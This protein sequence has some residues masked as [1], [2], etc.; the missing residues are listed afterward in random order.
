MI[1]WVQ[2]YTL[3]GE[4]SITAL[5]FLRLALNFLLERLCEWEMVIPKEVPLPQ[6]MHFAITAPPSKAIVESARA[7]LA[8]RRLY[9]RQKHAD[10]SHEEY[11]NR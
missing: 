8:T 11:I 2:T 7:K 9:M 6:L 3:F 5:T 4:P 10:N 1:Q